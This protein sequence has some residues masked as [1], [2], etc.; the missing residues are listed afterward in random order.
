MNLRF[1]T[2]IIIPFFSFNLFCQD[3][4]IKKDSSKIE[5]KLLEVRQTEIK[6]KVFNHQ[7]GPT[8]I[9]HK[10]EVA[11]VIYSN[12]LHEIFNNILTPIIEIKTDTAYRE[13]HL[14]NKKSVKDSTRRQLKIGDYIKFNVQ[15]GAVINNDYSNFTSRKPQPSHTSSE[16]YSGNNHEKYNYN[17][18]FGFNFLF[19][20]SPYIK[21]IIGINYLRSKG[22]FDYDFYQGGYTSYHQDFHYTS[23]VDFVNIVTGIRFAVGKHINI[24]PLIVFNCVAKVDERIT[25]T[26]TT[27]T[28]S[29]G[30]TPSVTNT[31]IEYLNNKSA[32]EY[33]RKI[34]STISLS[35]KISYEFKIKQQTLGAYFSCNLAYQYHLPWY[36]IGITYYP[37]KKLS[38]N[39]DNKKLRL[40]TNIKV[41]TELG[42]TL[43]NSLTNLPNS[44]NPSPPFQ[45]QEF[46]ATNKNIQTGINLGIN[47]ISGNNLYCK[48]I[49]GISYVQSKTEFIRSSTFRYFES[50]KLYYYSEKTNYQTN[51][52]FIAISTGIRFVIF[53]RINVDN[54]IAFNLPFSAQNKINGY[55]SHEELTRDS[56]GYYKRS[57]YS[58]DEIK[59]TSSEVL[60]KPSIAFS[61]KISCDFKIKQQTFGLFFN[62]NYAFKQ[63]IQWHMVGVTYYPFKKLK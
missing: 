62:F 37:F 24:E 35:P 31:E 49:M 38:P 43:N 17:I 18:N 40:F 25:G 26:I 7:D 2:A 4:I 45:Y 10:S 23:K 46:K 27:T 11:Y 51:T 21:H 36:M 39:M 14:V 44:K 50:D 1:L 61:P 29:G 52:H 53:K 19:G 41:N 55:K 20:K 63:N 22:E 3:T 28:I 12:G 59:T 48:H 9:I 56:Y 13:G 47:L 58:E 5:V 6:Y 42:I 57:D 15:C 54:S 60:M 33:N 32:G 8:H 30:P 16:E 34:Y